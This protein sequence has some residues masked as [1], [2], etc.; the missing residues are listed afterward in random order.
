MCHTN[1]ISFAAMEMTPETSAPGA[2][3]RTRRAPLEFFAWPAAGGIR[4][5]AVACEFGKPTC[6]SPRAPQVQVDFHME[7]SC[8]DPAWLLACSLEPYR[9]G[10]YSCRLTSTAGPP[11]S[12][13]VL[14]ATWKLP[15]E[16]NWPTVST[17]CLLMSWASTSRPF[18]VKDEATTSHGGLLVQLTTQQKIFLL[19]YEWLRSLRSWFI[20][21]EL[22]SEI[23]TVVSTGCQ[24]WWY[25]CNGHRQSNDHTSNYT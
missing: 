5:L 7:G 23:K 24:K 14:L 19:K 16:M 21:L 11:I 3:T 6:I 10:L 1:L 20:V 12:N 9:E 2:E 8:N 18:K 4:T 15:A 22:L 25:P 17:S 13:V